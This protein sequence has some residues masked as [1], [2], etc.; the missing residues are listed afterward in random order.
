MRTDDEYA[1]DAVRVEKVLMAKQRHGKPFAF[2]KGT[3]WTPRAVPFLTEWLQ[4]QKREEK[5]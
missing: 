4:S 3:D 5:K 2:E 1:L